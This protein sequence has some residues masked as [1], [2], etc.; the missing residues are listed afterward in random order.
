MR[1]NGKLGV[2]SPFTA[3]GNRDNLM[4][5][6]GNLDALGT[7]PDVLHTFKNRFANRKKHQEEVMNRFRINRWLIVAPVVL[8]ISNLFVGCVGSTN[9]LVSSELFAGWLRLWLGASELLQDQDQE[10]KP[11]AGEQSPDNRGKSVT[12]PSATKGHDVEDEDPKAKAED[13]I[14]DWEKPQFALFFSGN[15]KGYIEPCGCTGLEN[16]K[17]GLMRRH[18]VINVFQ[19]RGWDLIKI[20]SGDQVNRPGRQSLVKFETTLDALT[21]LMNYDVIG[22]GAGD[23]KISLIELATAMINADH[24]STPF[25]CAN[26]CLLEGMDVKLCQSH[27]IIEKNGKRIGITMVLGNEYLDSLR[28]IDGVTVQLAESALGRVASI[29]NQSKCDAKILVAATTTDECRKLASQFPD[30]DLIITTDC[31]GEPTLNPEELDTPRGKV[32]MVQIGAKSMY[33]GVVGFYFQNGQRGRA[34]LRYKRI[35]LDA[36]F[37]DSEEV[38]QVFVNYQNELKRMWVGGRFDDIRPHAHNSGHKFVGS[39]AC[40]DCHGEEY[41][42]WENGHDGEGGPHKHATASLTD[43]SERSWVQR[44]YDPECVSCHMTGWNPQGFFP[45]ESGYLNH[46]QDQRLFDNG[47]ENCH[48]PG[49]AH[50][51]AEENQENNAP[52]LEKLRLE[53]RVTLDEARKNA[54]AECHDLDNSPDFLREGAFDEYWPKIEH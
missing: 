45:Y 52:L 28:V 42:I 10:K 26:V 14:R 33:A 2:L 50:V 3:N 24:G 5:T 30:F 41:E 13:L 9:R 19:Q 12:Q 7:S 25:V 48:G 43:P 32:P 6:G 15:Q 31:G 39:E 34:T 51:D 40:A 44:H 8:V 35:P 49:S 37:K 21:R 46:D 23:F 36:R 11:A 20:D 27:R 54:C 47:C 18:S 22:L 17:G 53:M 16:Q 29:M 38:K 1:R 4:L